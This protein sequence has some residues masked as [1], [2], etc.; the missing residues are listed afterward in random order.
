MEKNMGHWDYGR[1]LPPE[2]WHLIEGCEAAGMMQSPIDIQSAA[3]KVNAKLTPI[4]AKYKPVSLESF[5]FTHL[6][7]EVEVEGDAG[8]I[9]IEGCYYPLKQFHVH[10]PAEHVIDGRLA[11]MEV[12]LVHSDGKRNYVLGV[13][14]DQGGADHPFIESLVDR[15]PHLLHKPEAFKLL[16]DGAPVV[17]PA[18]ILP[19]SASYFT[20]SGSLTT[21]PCT[22]NTSFF[23]FSTHISASD[24]QLAQFRRYV[25]GGNNRPVQPLNGRIVEYYSQP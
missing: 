15:L 21:P 14:V 13:F 4:V 7:L 9:E 12:H 10:T 8:G 20:Y 18:K 22:E 16:S 24:R 1:A 5:F 23:L 17:D 25:P 6:H 19:G 3:A 11:S 2:L